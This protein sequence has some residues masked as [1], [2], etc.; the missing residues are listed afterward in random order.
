M[1]YLAALILADL[2]SNTRQKGSNADRG[3]TRTPILSGPSEFMTRR[4]SWIIFRSE[5]ITEVTTVPV[6]GTKAHGE[7]GVAPPILML[8]TSWE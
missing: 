6:Q 3:L 4:P 5:Y 2:S 8:T 7:R 1:K